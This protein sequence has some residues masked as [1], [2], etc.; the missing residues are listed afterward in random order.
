MRDW[1]YGRFLIR[2]QVSLTVAPGGTG[3]SS[4][5]VVEALAL[6]TGRKLLHDTPYG[7]SRVWLWNGEDPLDELQRRIMAAC[8][9]YG[10]SREEIADGLF[11]D[12][13]RNTEIIIAR[14][15]RNEVKIAVPVFDALVRTIEENEIDV[16]S[17]DP[18]VSC[19]AVPENDNGAIDRVVKTYAKIADKTGCA[20]H[21]V[22]HSRKTAARRSRLSTPA[23]LWR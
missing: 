12:S 7:Q 23:A 20:I 4:L 15:E 13:G 2:R 22:H 16:V 8:V 1:L 19:H 21:L 5:A 3:K 6:A 18:F 11:V 9:H 14:M 17:I 10:I